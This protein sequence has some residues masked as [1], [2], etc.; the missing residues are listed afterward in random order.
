[1]LRRAQRNDFSAIARMYRM[2]FEEMAE[3]QPGYWRAAEQSEDFFSSLFEDGSWDI[4][5][6]EEDSVVAGFVVL[7]EE[8]TPPYPCVEPHRFA[9]LMDMMVLPQY[10]GCG[11]GT[12]L[13][14]RAAAWAQERGF[15][16]V[17]LHVLE[18][19]RNATSLYER[20]GF[21]SAMRTMRRRLP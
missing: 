10:R 9:Y 6:V 11:H 20:C 4:F 1:M 5:V 7:K 12:R 3:L 15:D 21:S 8:S 17:E 13:I 2:L 19:N 18:E 16:Y 14:E